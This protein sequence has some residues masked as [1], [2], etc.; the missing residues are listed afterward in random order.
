MLGLLLFA[1]FNSSD[2]FLLLKAKNAGM[3]DTKVIGIYIRYNLAYALFA[4]PMGILAD[5]FGLKQIFIFGLM[6]FSLVYFGMAITQSQWAM[7]I[8]FIYMDCMLPQTKA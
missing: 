5:R 4:F 8:F 1:L 2:M 3:D 7:A 6:V